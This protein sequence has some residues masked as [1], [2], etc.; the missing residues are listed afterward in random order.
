[1]RK[2]NVD[3]IVENY[4]IGKRLCKKVN[5]F[6]KNALSDKLKKEGF[7]KEEQI[8]MLDTIIYMLENNSILT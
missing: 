8:Q 4:E 7:T 5:L 1:M 3:C 2:H 6:W